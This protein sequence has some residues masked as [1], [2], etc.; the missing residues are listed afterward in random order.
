MLV[1]LRKGYKVPW[2]YQRFGQV[3]MEL[4]QVERS[5][6]RS[7]AAADTEADKNESDPLLSKRLELWEVLHWWG[8]WQVQVWEKRPDS[9]REKPVVMPANT[10][11]VGTQTGIRLE[12]MNMFDRK[13]DYL[14]EVLDFY[15]ERRSAAFEESVLIAYSNVQGYCSQCK[16][17]QA[18]QRKRQLANWHK[19]HNPYCRCGHPFA[20]KRLNTTSFSGAC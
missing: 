16:H 20:D 3:A 9:A 19:W 8:V 14:D 4:L 18:E 5:R 11:T 10:Q 13:L 2:V 12:E 6:S 1:M 7:A 17:C 15:L